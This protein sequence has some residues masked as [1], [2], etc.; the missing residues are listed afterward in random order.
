[1]RPLGARLG[2]KD[3]D[4]ILVKRRRALQYS[5]KIRRGWAVSVRS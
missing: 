1:M 5:G 3:F 4:I 2:R